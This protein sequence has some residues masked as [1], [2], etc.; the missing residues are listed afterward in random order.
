MK[1]NAGK[2][3]TSQEVRRLRDGVDKELAGYTA[4]QPVVLD[5][6]DYDAL[7]PKGD[8]DR[9]VL[10]PRLIKAI[11]EEIANGHVSAIV[12]GRIIGL[13]EKVVASYLAKGNDDLEQGLGT[14][15]AWFAVLVNRAEGKVQSSLIA[16]VRDNP[17]GWMNQS[18]LLEHLWPENFAIQ[19]LAQ[20]HVVAS[21]LETELRKQLDDARDG[22]GIGGAPLPRIIDVLDL[23]NAEEKEPEE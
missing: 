11:C 20:K 5:D 19:R 13:P 22:R 12:A 23:G 14:R 17:L 7:P 3:M 8:G 10:T 16:A 2:I 15:M 21:S 18:F 1:G 4:P 6:V 9:D